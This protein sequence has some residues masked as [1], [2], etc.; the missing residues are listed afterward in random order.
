[1]KKHGINGFMCTEDRARGVEKIQWV[2]E[3]GVSNVEIV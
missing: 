1:M 2:M 3:L